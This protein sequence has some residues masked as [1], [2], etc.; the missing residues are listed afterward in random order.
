VLPPELVQVSVYALVVPSAPVGSLPANAL[1]PDQAPDAVHDVA[2][3]D[4]HVS[5]E[6]PPLETLAGLAPKMTDGFGG[7]GGEFW[8]VTIVVCVVAPPDPVQV[9]E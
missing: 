2:S 1:L 6:V 8:T 5:S 4:D 7:G 9:N 3:L